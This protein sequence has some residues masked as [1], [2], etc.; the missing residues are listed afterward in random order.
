MIVT[1]NVIQTAYLVVLLFD[2][3]SVSILLMCIIN[4]VICM[5]KRFIHKLTF[6]V[7]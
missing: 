7:I 5:S 3:L 6:D 2:I 1:S 4:A